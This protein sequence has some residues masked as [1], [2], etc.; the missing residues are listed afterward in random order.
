[1]REQVWYE[2]LRD[3]WRPE[4]VRLLLI[5]ESAPEPSGVNRRFK[6]GCV[7]NEPAGWQPIDVTKMVAGN[8]AGALFPYGWEL[9]GPWGSGETDTNDLKYFCSD[10]LSGLSYCNI[11]SATR[12]W[13]SP[14]AR[15]WGCSRRS[16]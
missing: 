8:T 15:M 16:R 11:T 5:G 14:T 1:M 10:N 12:S 4:Q 6:S 7:P 2:S 13:R 9:S 3:Q